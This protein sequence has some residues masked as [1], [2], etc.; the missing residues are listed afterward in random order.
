MVVRAGGFYG[1]S[2]PWSWVST[3]TSGSRQPSPWVTLWGEHK[4]LFPCAAHLSKKQVPWPQLCLPT[5]PCPL[6]CPKCT[7]Q[8]ARCHHPEWAQHQPRGSSSTPQEE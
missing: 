4:S 1:A 6:H 3:F 7:E 5:I 2:Y 8:A